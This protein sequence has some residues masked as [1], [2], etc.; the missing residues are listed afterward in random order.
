MKRLQDQCDAQLK[1]M[2]SQAAE[3]LARCACA[4]VCMCVCLSLYPWALLLT[5]FLV[6][7]FR[8]ELRAL[9]QQLE[10]E[11]D[12]AV[13][14]ERENSRQR[15]QKQSAIDE[16]QNQEEV[17]AMNRQEEGMRAKTFDARCPAMAHVLVCTYTCCSDSG[18]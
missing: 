17:R 11:R 5:T 4:C 3:Q 8:R 14:E 13:L 1:L 2:E 9:R 12:Q 15:F 16:R 18:C 10:A 7:L 6:C